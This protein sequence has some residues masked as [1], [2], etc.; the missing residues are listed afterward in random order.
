VI[1]DTVRYVNPAMTVRLEMFG[2]GKVDDHCRSPEGDCASSLIP[3]LR[4]EDQPFQVIVPPHPSLN[5][6]ERED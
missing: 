4:V 3:V 6:H 5:A 1:D 2:G